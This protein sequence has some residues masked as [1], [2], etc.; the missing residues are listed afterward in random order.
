MSNVNTPAADTGKKESSV[1]Y[2]KRIGPLKEQILYIGER[3]MDKT[4]WV[5]R[6]WLKDETGLVNANPA[7]PA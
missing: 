7:K 2:K 6:R 1:A 3:N 4:I 5:I